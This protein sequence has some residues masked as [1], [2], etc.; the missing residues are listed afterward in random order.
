MI[1]DYEIGKPSIL[2]LLAP[3]IMKIISSEIG[4]DVTWTEEFG[5]DGLVVRIANGKTGKI[6]L[7]DLEKWFNDGDYEAI[8]LAAKSLGESLRK[9]NFEGA[10]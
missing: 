1:F 4:T 5:F 9:E 10:V 8:N 7:V 6:A 2:A 3:G